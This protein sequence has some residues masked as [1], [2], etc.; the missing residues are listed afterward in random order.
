MSAPSRSIRIVGAREHNLQGL[1]RRHSR[2][3]ADRR[4]RRVGLGQ[5]V[6]GVRH[7]LRR[8]PAPLR[9]ELLDLR[10]P[11]PR[12]HGSA[13]ASSGSTASCRR[14]RSTRAGPCRRRARR[15]GTMTELHDYLKL[16]YAK[17]GVPHCR[18]CGKLGPRATPPR[19][20]PSSLL[21]AHDGAR[22]LVA[23]EVPLPSRPARGRRSAP[24]LLAAGFIRALDDAGATVDLDGADRADGRRARSRSSRTAS[25]CATRRARAARRLARAGAR[26]TAAAASPCLPPDGR[27]RRRT[28][29]PRSSARACGFTVR[30]P[31]PNLFS[32]N[33]PLGACEACRGFGRIIDLDLDLVVPDPEAVDRR[34]A[35]CKP[36][37]DE[38]DDAGSAASCSGAASATASRPTS[39]GATLDRRAAPRSIVDGDGRGRMAGIRGWFKW[40]EGRTYKMHVRVFLARYRS[41]TRVPGLRRRA[42]SS[43]RRS[44]SASP[45]RPIADVNRLPIARGAPLLRPSSPSAG[46][47][48][49]RSPR[50]ILAEV[51]SR[52]ALPGRGRARV[53]DAR[54]PVAHAVRRRA[55]ARRP[56]DRRRLVAREHALRARRAVDRPPPARHRSG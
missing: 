51:Q 38:D 44:T 26:A 46:Q 40:L 13:A 21:A 7:P 9:R 54:P 14:S 35:P 5:V 6:A 42:R 12:S 56:D 41:Y 39:R 24:G 15:V 10:A 22:A 36:W 53:P 52:L 31:V 1:R 50:L 17:L 20:P 25:C 8:G 43:P 23:F 18:T 27:R 55:R 30:E 19:A 11:V 33:S 2:R 45:A 3:A 47:D 49:R 32:F 4:H 48:A 28:S 34:A 16:L 29:R 37:I